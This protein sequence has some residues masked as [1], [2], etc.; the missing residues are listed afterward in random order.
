MTF[1]LVIALVIWL[2][3]LQNK[4]NE[5]KKRMDAGVVVSAK[6]PVINQAQTQAAALQAAGVNVSTAPQVAAV[7]KEVKTPEQAEEASGRLLGR[8]GIVALIAGVAFFLK[9]AFDND[10]ISYTGRVMLGIVIGVALIGLGQWL[11]KK[12]LK[13]SDLL[14][15]GGVAVLYLSVFAAHSLYHLI[16]QPVAL[17]VMFC[18]TFL[19]FAVSVVNATMTFAMIGVIGGFLTPLIISFGKPDMVALFSYLV[20]MNIGVFAVSI[21]KKW[22]P[23]N[24][25]AFLVTVINFM[26]WYGS[27]YTDGD[28][29]PTLFFLTIIFFIYILVSLIYNIINKTKAAQLDYGL[30]GA[31]AIVYSGFLYSLLDPQYGD[32]L[33]FV[34]V[35]LALVYLIVAFLANKLNPEDKGIN[36]FLPGLTVVF[37]SIAVPLQLDGLWISVAWLVESV[38]LYLLAAKIANR[39]FQV[40]GVIVYILGILGLLV[41]YSGI[42]RWYSYG[43]A[44]IEFVP[45]FNKFFAIGVLAIIVSYVITYIYRAYGSI[46]PEIQKR[47]IAVFLVMS[48]LLTI[49]IV[50]MELHRFYD[51]KEAVVQARQTSAEINYQVDTRLQTEKTEFYDAIERDYT[52][53]RNEKN[54]VISIFWALYAGI[55]LAV[56]FI[57]PSL[58]ARRFGIILFVITAAKIF[59]DIWNIGPL[60]RII[61]SIVFGLIAL[62]GSFAYAKY[63]DRLN[64]IV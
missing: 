57:K 15:G 45:V 56:G 4:V 41:E 59:I 47:G 22:I 26:T 28:L 3:V 64:K 5:L 63:K 50:S 61:S 7:Q 48:Q 32:Y 16:S 53:I 54:I 44:V 46:T 43:D 2:L 58:I 6:A 38:V 29:V 35:L 49:G 62:I 25:V 39:G 23:L 14:M 1:I 19:A 33:G 24:Y 51:S 9:Y 31:N 12:Y 10:W 27:S 30:M 17:V 18:I 42:D 60:Y 20:V 21:Y 13:Y 11:R 52:S 55:L 34:F 8:I 40:M 37:L 36:I